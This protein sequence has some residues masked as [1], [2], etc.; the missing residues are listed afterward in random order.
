MSAAEALITRADIEEA[1]GRI[2]GRIRRTPVI[3]LEPGAFGLPGRLSLKLEQL[4]HSGSFKARGAFNLLLKRD[5]PEVG[6]V[7]ASGG[8][9]GLAIAFAARALGHHATIFVPEASSPA[10]QAKL[11]ALGAE[12]VVTGR[13]YADALAASQQRVRRDRRPLRPCL[14]SARGRSWGRNLRAR[15]RPA[16]PED[17]HGDGRDRGR[18]A[19]RRYRQLV[20]RHDKGH[21]GRIGAD[22]DPGFGAEPLAN[23]STSNWVALRPMRWAP[24]ASATMASR[25]PGAGWTGRCSSRTRRSSGHSRRSGTAYA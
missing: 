21:L 15:T 14:R 10:K 4:Q 11:R 9:F 16:A 18:R 2:D 12:L 23:R 5:V 8:N 25:R 1:D 24:S 13:F 17:R 3:E 7:A 22:L 6:V 19:H 20:W